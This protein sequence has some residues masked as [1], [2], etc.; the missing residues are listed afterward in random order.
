MIEWVWYIKSMLDKVRKTGA[1]SQEE[2][3]LLLSGVLKGVDMCKEKS[4]VVIAYGHE[5]TIDKISISLLD[6]SSYRHGK[7]NSVESF[8]KLINSLELKNE[9]WIYART[10]EENNQY[11]LKSFFPSTKFEEVIPLLNDRSIQKVLR[12]IDSKDLALA[13]KGAKYTIQEAVFK[14][15]SQRAATMLKEDMEYMGPVR[16]IDHEDAKEKILNII[17]HL[18]DTGEIVIRRDIE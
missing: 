6:S 18:E 2:I 10:I 7:L 5:K 3:D 1:L 12:E 16:K 9:K 14:N 13:L 8:C 15:M 4:L 11:P 17:F